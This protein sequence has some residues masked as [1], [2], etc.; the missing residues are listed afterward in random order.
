MSGSAQY[1]VLVG[2]TV[3][4]VVL[5]LLMMLTADGSVSVAIFGGAVLAIGG[6]FAAASLVVSVL[7][8]GFDE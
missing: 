4:L 5:G 7:R 2:M 8:R 6:S 1:G 3:A